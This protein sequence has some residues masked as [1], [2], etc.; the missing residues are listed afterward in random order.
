MVFRCETMSKG[1]H[2]ACRRVKLKL[3]GVEPLAT[4]L[5]RHRVTSCPLLLHL[6]QVGLNL[7]NAGPHGIPPPTQDDLAIGVQ[8]RPA[9][10]RN[11]VSSKQQV[12]GTS[13]NPNPTTNG[14]KPR[15]HTSGSHRHAQHVQDAG[16]HTTVRKPQEIPGTKPLF[17]GTPWQAAPWSTLAVLAGTPGS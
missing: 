7:C 11:L 13:S 3:V 17:G 6:N 5:N 16:L 15:K 1:A 10:S 9:S 8:H 14:M 12:H 4:P 2:P